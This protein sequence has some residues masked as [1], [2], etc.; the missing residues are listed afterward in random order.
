MFGRLFRKKSQ[1]ERND[2][3]SV[4]T[5]QDG[6]MP[7]IFRIRSLPDNFAK[8]EYP[9]ML[10]ISWRYGNANGGMPLPDEKARMDL[11]EDLLMPA[12]E[13]VNNAILT[14]IVTG[15]GV[16]E[17]QWYTRSPDRTM[18]LV[19]TALAGQTQFPVEFIIQDDP[20]WEAF[21]QFET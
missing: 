19:N 16:R 1:P 10:A 20:D 9:T 21:S 8:S 4:A 2:R 7:L 13:P 12:L 3:W 6:D 5:A 15:N 14:V 18:E 11:L 17:W